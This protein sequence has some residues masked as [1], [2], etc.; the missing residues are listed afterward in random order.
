[1][2]QRLAKLETFFAAEPSDS[3]VLYALAQEHAKLGQLAT[4]I[5]WYDRCLE[6][7]PASCYAYFHKAQ[8]QITLGDQ[9]GAKATLTLGV[10]AATKAQDS[11]ALGEI[12]GLLD[13]LE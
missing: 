11:K 6:V 10:A 7:D 1:M 8:V 4:A 12:R 13:E 9:S 2:S 3:F 5:Q